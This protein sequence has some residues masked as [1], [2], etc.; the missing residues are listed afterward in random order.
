MPSIWTALL[1]AEVRFVQGRQYRHRVIEAGSGPPLILIH[2][3]GSSAE[4]F[5]HNVLPLAEHF[6]VLAIDAL[7]H[8]YSSLEPYDADERVRA[9]ADAV[10]DFMDALGI[11][12]AHLE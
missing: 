8:G 6:R 7:Y 12:R 9:Q 5:A 11:E 10:L 4:L 2:G 1:G 3:V